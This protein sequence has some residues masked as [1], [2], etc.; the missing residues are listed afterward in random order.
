MTLKGRGCILF[1]L[2]HSSTINLADAITCAYQLGIA[3][4]L[5]DTALYLRQVILKAFGESADLP[6]P[7]TADELDK[8]MSCLRNSGG[9]ST[10]DCLAM[11][12][13]WISL[14]HKFMWKVC[15]KSKQNLGGVNDA[16]SGNLTGGMVSGVSSFS[17][18]LFFLSVLGWAMGMGH[19]LLDHDATST[20]DYIWAM[21]SCY[22]I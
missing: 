10:W 14:C 11:T 9:S 8:R 17:L 18:F 16:F 7:P 4:H 3:D 19:Y 15:W 20:V 13:R 12:L 21:Y 22:L 6:W 1:W 5:K 2:V